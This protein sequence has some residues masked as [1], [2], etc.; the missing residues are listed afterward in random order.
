LA[1][2]GQASEVLEGVSK[3]IEGSK[4]SDDRSK[5]RLKEAGRA[6]LRRLADN[7]PTFTS[8]GIY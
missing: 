7:Q 8:D 6:K 5:K 1:S 3:L 4:A 2:H